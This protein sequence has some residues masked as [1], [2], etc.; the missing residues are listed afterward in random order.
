M[1]VTLARYL[2]APLRSV[3]GLDSSRRV[4]RSLLRGLPR[5]SFG[6]VA[7]GA[8]E[9]M[10]P[11]K[12]CRATSTPFSLN[13]CTALMTDSRSMSGSALMTSC[14][15]QAPPGRTARASNT[16]AA[17]VDMG[18]QYKATEILGNPCLRQTGSEMDRSGHP[19]CTSQW[20]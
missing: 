11:K 18:R 15:E 10:N 13:L 17:I 8:I 9:Y 16:A 6:R 1:R 20:L 2:E 12:L 5:P 14:I 3:A 19:L 7:P 4:D